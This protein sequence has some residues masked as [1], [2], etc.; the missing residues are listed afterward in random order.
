M[1]IYEI[2]LKDWKTKDFIS[3]Q[4]Y[5]FEEKELPSIHQLKTWFTETQDEISIRKLPKEVQD[6]IIKSVLRQ[7]EIEEIYNLFGDDM[8]PL[9]ELTE[10][11]E[12][13][14]TIDEEEIAI[15]DITFTENLWQK[16][17]KENK[18]KNK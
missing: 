1:Q 2:R 6:V 7:N 17:I 11:M 10:L 13:P 8:T 9:H 14:E 5:M 18:E 4:I 15:I 12:D 3:G 16:I